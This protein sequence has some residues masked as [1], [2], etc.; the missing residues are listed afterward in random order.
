MAVQSGRRISIYSLAVLSY[1]ANG[2]MSLNE[3][4]AVIQKR[5]RERE[6]ERTRQAR[7]RGLKKLGKT[8]G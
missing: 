1:V 6:M 4:M 2:T 8:L 7:R 3:A 5:N